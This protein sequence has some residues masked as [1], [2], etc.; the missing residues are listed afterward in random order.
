[1]PK[2]KISDGNPNDYQPFEMVVG[3]NRDQDVQVGITVRDRLPGEYPDAE[4]DTLVDVLYAAEHD[5]IGE[6]FLA[7]LAH[8]GRAIT[9]A[10]AD[11]A[12]NPA[13][14]VEFTT[15]VIG[16]LA[17]NSVARSTQ[18]GDSVWWRPTRSAI[19]TLIRT[20]R[21]ARDQAFGKDE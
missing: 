8:H 2:E 19:N 12:N 6:A 18:F 5:A 17:L 1:M 10:D 9:D 14:A 16:C 21:R 20:L 3:W 13:H 11:P 4:P 15:D 7:H